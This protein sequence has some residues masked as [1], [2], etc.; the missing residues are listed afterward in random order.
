[1]RVVEK[2]QP[3]LASALQANEASHEGRELAGDPR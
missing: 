3:W 1:M 2:H